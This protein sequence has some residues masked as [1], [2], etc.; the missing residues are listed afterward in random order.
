MTDALLPWATAIYDNA[1]RSWPDLTIDQFRD[2]GNDWLRRY[3]NSR[4]WSLEDVRDG[5]YRELCDRY[6][7][8]VTQP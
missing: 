6:G 3:D 4:G 2:A 7:E 1:Q 5:V 8:S